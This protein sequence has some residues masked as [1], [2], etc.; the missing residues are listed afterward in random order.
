MNYDTVV[1]ELLSRPDNPFKD[2]NQAK[3]RS[4]LVGYVEELTTWQHPA[5][6]L[7]EML[8][9]DEEIEALTKVIMEK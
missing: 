4:I 5:T 8:E 6:I 7:Q 3:A 1:E 2:L 9:S